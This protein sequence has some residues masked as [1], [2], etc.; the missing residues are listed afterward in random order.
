MTATEVLVDARGPRRTSGVATLGA[1]APHKGA[2]AIFAGPFG[3]LFLL[4]YLIPI[5]YAIWQSLL[6]VERDGTFGAPS[7]VFGGLTQY[8]LVFQNAPFWESVGRVLVFGV[9]QVPVMLGLALLLRAAARLAGA[10]GQEVLPARVLRAVRGARRD[11]GDHVGLPLLAQPVAVHGRD[12]RRIDF[13]SPELVLW[14]IA[15]VVTWVFVG[16]N[17]LI[18]YSALQAIPAELYEAARLDGAGQVRIAWS[19]K[20]PMVAP[21]LIL[22]ARLLDHRH[23][24]AA[25]R[26]AGVPLVQRG[27]CRAP[28]PRT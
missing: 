28:T 1:T 4:F 16:Y 21:A 17:M 24:P 22:T 23:A 12:A 7:E 8:A 3:V 19:I 6:V 5:G 26:A 9:V 13:L 10:Q 2:I 11:R 14:S 20:I 18:I 27:A 25:R 15:N